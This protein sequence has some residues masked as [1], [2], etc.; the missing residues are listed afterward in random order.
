MFDGNGP[1]GRVTIGIERKTIGD[2]VSSLQGGRLQGFQY[3]KLHD[4]YDFV[5]LLVEGIWSTDAQGRLT[6]RRGQFGMRRLPGAHMTEDGLTKALI[7]LEVKGG[8]KVKQTFNQAQSVTWLTSMLRWWTDKLWE[9]HKTLLTPYSGHQVI[10]QISMFREMV[11]KLPDVGVSAS[12]AVE[13]AFDG[14]MDRVLHSHAADWSELEIVTPAGPRRLGD[15][16]AL[17]IIDAIAKLR[18]KNER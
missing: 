9:G 16:R 1:D 7:T 3:G 2:L 11:M 13:L 10:G 17:R 5:W 14:D 6:I 8:L 4:T 15:N 12:K 18:R